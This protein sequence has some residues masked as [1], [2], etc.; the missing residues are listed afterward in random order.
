MGAGVDGAGGADA[1]R[2]AAVDAP[3]GDRAAGDGGEV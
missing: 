1:M 2:D 3:P